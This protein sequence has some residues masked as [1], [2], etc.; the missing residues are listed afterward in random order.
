[1]GAARDLEGDGWERWEMM[2]EGDGAI[3]AGMEEGRCRPER[4]EME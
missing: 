1:M 4:W 2:R 3:S